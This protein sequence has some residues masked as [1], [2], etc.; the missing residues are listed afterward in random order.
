MKIL[1]RSD[2]KKHDGICCA[3]TKSGGRCKRKSVKEGLCK[4]HYEIK[5]SIVK[6]FSDYPGG[7]LE[8]VPDTPPTLTGH[9]A[10]RWRQICEHL[11]SLKLLYGSMLYSILSLI[12]CE[13][14]VHDLSK[15]IRDG[16][17]DKFLNTY[18]SESGHAGNQVN[19]EWSILT[20]FKRET[21]KY[22]KELGL[23]VQITAKLMEK[24]GNL[25]KQNDQ[26]STLRPVK[27]SY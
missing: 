11:I 1:K 21:E 7:Q 14:I 15:P 13:E 19:G 9:S 16:N 24:T 5:K 6:H 23:D 10:N 20:Q 17:V 3:L 2:Q 22:R 25:T 27:K 4:Q 12:N 8:Q 18:V 26:P